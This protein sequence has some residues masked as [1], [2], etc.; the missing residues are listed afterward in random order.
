MVRA[1]RFARIALRI[2][3]ATKFRSLKPCNFE[4]SR[5]FDEMFTWQ[6]FSPRVQDL[7]NTPPKSTPPKS[8]RQPLPPIGQCKPKLLAFP[9]GKSSPP[10]TQGKGLEVDDHPPPWCRKGGGQWGQRGPAP[11]A[12][13]SCRHARSYTKEEETTTNSG[14][15]PPP[16]KFTKYCLLASSSAIA[17]EKA[18]KTPQILQIDVSGKCTESGFSHCNF[19]IL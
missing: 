13:S 7:A 18:L 10:R 16:Q 9:H 2:A 19:R 11:W 12:E 6:P 17:R 8:R 5:A 14:H 4:V 15:P 3:R 1:N